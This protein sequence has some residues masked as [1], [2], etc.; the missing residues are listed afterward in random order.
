MTEYEFANSVAASPNSFT[1]TPKQL[2][3][4]DVRRIAI[5]EYE[6]LAE[7]ALKR[8]PTIHEVLAEYEKQ[9]A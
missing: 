3:E 1:K 7:L 9:N 2:T 6:R 4:N 8:F 5:E